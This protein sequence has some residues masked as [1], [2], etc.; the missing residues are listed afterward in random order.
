MKAAEA[1]AKLYATGLPAIR[2]DEVAAMLRISSGATAQLL[3]RLR[4]AKLVQPLMRGAVWIGQDTIEPWLVVDL[5]AWPYP[6]YGSLY[7]A[8]YRHGALSQI[9]SVHYAVTLGRAHHVRTTVG[10]YSLHRI[11]ANLFDGFKTTAS[12]EKFATLEKAL[13]DLAYLSSTRFRLFARPPEIELP[14]ALDRA[15]LRRWIALIRSPE[16]RTHAQ[17]YLDA[18]ITAPASRRRSRPRPS[19]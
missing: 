18:L 2:N 5:V 16:R 12:G 7:S 6:A 3:R 1:Y 10:T 13:F 4:Q 19:R 17:R 9:P 15:A 14:R 11:D 8:L